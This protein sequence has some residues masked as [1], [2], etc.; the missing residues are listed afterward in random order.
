VNLELSSRIYAV[1]RLAPDAPLPGWALAGEF[2][3][4][5]RTRDELSVVC[6]ERL[7]PAPFDRE[8]SWRV[9]K[10]GG[11]L[12]SSLVG[13]LA[14]IVSPLA[15]AGVSIFAISTFDTDYVLVKDGGLVTA[16]EALR[17]AGHSVAS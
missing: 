7:V 1:V 10:V 13:V 17:S 5:T 6:E 8:G 2:V 9:L 14:S 3:S 15:S 16:L 4:L 11:P 12:G